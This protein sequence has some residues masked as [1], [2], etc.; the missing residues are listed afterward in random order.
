MF[1][2]HSGSSSVVLETEKSL[3]PQRRNHKG[4][5]TESFRLE[6][7][8][9]T[10]LFQVPCHGQGHLPPAQG[11]QSPIQPG[12]EHCQG[13]GVNSVQNNRFPRPNPSRT[14][15]IPRLAVVQKTG[16][17]CQGLST[18]PCEISSPSRLTSDRTASSTARLLPLIPLECMC[19]IWHAHF[20]IKATASASS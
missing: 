16:R 19:Q 20:I 5:I 1:Y 4:G 11:A 9:K 8:L 3:L 18:R 10:I 6:G 2:K 12:L 15:W 14:A 17:C 7:T 13:G